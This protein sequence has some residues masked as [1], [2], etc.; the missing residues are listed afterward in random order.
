VIE[1]NQ[2]LWGRIHAFRPD[3]L[4]MPSPEREFLMKTIRRTL[5]L[6]ILSVASIQAQQYVISTYAGG[7]PPR[8]PVSGL[9]IV[10]TPLSMAADT[11]GNVYFVSANC[12]FKLD[13][14]GIVTRVAGNSRVGYFGDGGSALNAQFGGAIR[15]AVDATG[16]LYIADSLNHRVR[17]VSA[18]V[19]TTI[20][21]DGISEYSG[22]G[23]PAQN[24]RLVGPSDM[25][26]DGS[27]SLFLIDGTRIRKISATGLITTVAGDSSSGYS[28]DGGPAVNATFCSPSGIVVDGSGSVY[29]GDSQAARVRRISADGIITT[30]VGTGAHG[31]TGD[32]GPA[33]DAQI[34]SASALALD[35][36]GNLYVLDTN[37]DEFNSSIRKVSLAGIITTVAIRSTLVD[38]RALAL[39][40]DGSLYVAQVNFGRISKIEADGSVT[41]VAGRPA[42]ADDFLTALTAVSAQFY[43][44]IGVAVDPQGSVY[45]ADTFIHRVRVISPAG[46]ITTIAGNG[47]AGFSGDGG[48]AIEA[49]IYLPTGVA[50]DSRG[51]LYIADHG[52]RRIRKVSPSGT[53]T[54]VAGTG[55]NVPV[56][57]VWAVAIDSADNLYVPDTSSHQIRRISTDG[58]VTIVA[59]DGTQGYSGDGGP[60]TKAKLL[61]GDKTVLTTDRQGNLYFVDI[62]VEPPPPGQNN[63]V[64]ASRVRKVSPDG[65][66]TTVA[67][68]GTASDS[69][70]GGLGTQAGLPFPT[71]LATD[72]GGNLYIADAGT[73]TIRMLSPSGI[74]TT[75]AGTGNVGYTGDGGLATIAQFNGPAGLAIDAF[76]NLFV[77]DQ[78]NNA[79]R[80]LQPVSS[81]LSITGIRNAADNRSGPISPGEIVVLSGSG[82]G[83]A[84]LFSASVGADGVFDTQL[85]ETSVEFNGVPAALIYT[86]ATQVAAVVPTSVGP[87]TAQIAVGYQHQISALFSA[88]VAPSAPGIFTLDATGSGQ[89]VAFNQD[90]AINSPANPAKSGEVVSILVTGVGAT[91]PSLDGEIVTTLVPLPLLPVTVSVSGEPVVPIYAGGIP[92]QIAGLMQ[93][94]IQLPD[95]ITKGPYTPVTVQIGNA[96][97]QP[98]V[99]IAVQ[100]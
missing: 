27:G 14:S 6:L 37:D 48:L 17:R 57:E 13:R 88:D 95:N 83:P 5:G 70:A 4:Y 92:G 60:A 45:I 41:T 3:P 24:A 85:A 38:S 62:D 49:S 34:T 63:V 43:G 11:Q 35:H 65:I 66:I 76:G 53:I 10:I 7:A 19:I 87:G 77:A 59:G 50:L 39:D 44:P 84:K 32:G 94:K 18:G 86:S 21:G 90:G 74:I 72:S 54:T 67:G 55:T 52:N 42:S 100:Q 81:R 2:T 56:G 51:N 64:A 82:L 40:P 79:I 28:G 16:N 75:I 96:S 33:I 30:V 29:I 98:D 46:V 97:S 93:I 47:N 31:Q 23:G 91:S 58:A 99:T 8:S 80:V 69:G 15:V 1:G 36:D 89:A 26:A 73:A 71:G 20:A 22:D 9:N 61:L 68:N 12:V 78:F 25:A